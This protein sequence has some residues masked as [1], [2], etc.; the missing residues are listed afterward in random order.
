M[1]KEEE[2]TTKIER[3][4]FAR[5]DIWRKRCILRTQALGEHGKDS[6]ARES[7]KEKM[8]HDWMHRMHQFALDTGNAGIPKAQKVN[9][10]VVCYGLDPRSLSLHISHRVKN[11]ECTLPPKGIED[12]LCS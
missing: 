7:L 6:A 11:E 8:Q 4:S 9:S 5:R 10:G 1:R 2:R 3:A 12:F